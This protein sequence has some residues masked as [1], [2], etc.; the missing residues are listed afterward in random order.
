VWIHLRLSGLAG[1]S[2][3]LVPRITGATV[4]GLGRRLLSEV[5]P[6]AI[7]LESWPALRIWNRSLARP[8]EADATEGDG[9]A[10]VGEHHRLSDLLLS[11]GRGDVLLSPWISTIPFILGSR[12]PVIRWIG[13]TRIGPVESWRVRRPDIPLSPHSQGQSPERYYPPGRLLGQRRRLLLRS[14]RR[15]RLS[16]LFLSFRRS[17]ASLL[18]IPR[19]CMPCSLT[20][21]TRSASARHFPGI[22]AGSPAGGRGFQGKVRYLRDPDPG[23]AWDLDSAPAVGSDQWV[24]GREPR[25]EWTSAGF[26]GPR[27]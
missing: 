9:H 8:E 5:Q 7:Y 23:Q 17:Y 21:G 27:R 18:P 1:S 16:F 6:V 22:R 19:C 13:S 10:V 26:P 14:L 3:T 25:R 4:A 15:R 2:R 20:R 24:R 12:D 11:R